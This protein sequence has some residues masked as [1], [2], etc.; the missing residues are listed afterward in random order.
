MAQEIQRDPLSIAS[1]G[2]PGLYGVS[3]S[4]LP[5]TEGDVATR[6]RAL[7]PQFSSPSVTTV[8]IPVFRPTAQAALPTPLLQRPEEIGRAA[9]RPISGEAQFPALRPAET[10]EEIDQRLNAVFPL[11]AP[12]ALSAPVAPNLGQPT[13]PTDVSPAFGKAGRGRGLPMGLTSPS[14]TGSIFEEP[15]YSYLPP[16]LPPPPPTT[17]QPPTMR[18]ERARLDETTPRLDETTPRSYSYNKLL[19]EIPRTTSPLPWLSQLPPIQQGV[20]VLSQQLL[21]TPP[22]PSPLPPSPP[23][24]VWIPEIDTWNKAF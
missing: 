14:G 20:P 16:G 15:S 24:E 1:G 2:L 3:F 18:L 10:I 6:S 13:S 7:V 23:M 21:V 17:W 4:P 5:P 22:P 19:P 8:S 9:F 12:Y 11:Q